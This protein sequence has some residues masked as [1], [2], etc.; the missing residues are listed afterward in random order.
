MIGRVCVVL[1]HCYAWDEFES[2]EEIKAVAGN[3]TIAENLIESY[4]NECINKA[5]NEG[6]L[7]MDMTEVGGNVTVSLEM[8]YD[9]T[10]YRYRY[11]WTIEQFDI[12][13]S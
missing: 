1:E 9:G 6:G 8:H 3:P 2:Y 4:K 13:E 5:Y 11:F 7:A 10:T 12:I